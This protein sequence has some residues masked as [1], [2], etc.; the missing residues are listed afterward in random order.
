[1]LQLKNKKPRPF[2]FVRTRLHSVEKHPSVLC[3]ALL[4]SETK[5]IFFVGADMGLCFGFVLKSVFIIQ[6]GSEHLGRGHRQD[7]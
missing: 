4:L 2:N 3:G 1:M 6:A 7:K 5:P